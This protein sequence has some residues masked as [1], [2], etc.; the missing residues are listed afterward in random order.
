MPR[1]AQEKSDTAADSIVVH[2]RYIILRPESHEIVYI[3]ES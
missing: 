1:Q 2:G 3:I